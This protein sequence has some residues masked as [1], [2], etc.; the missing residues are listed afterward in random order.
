MTYQVTN[1]WSVPDGNFTKDADIWP[2]FSAKWTADQVSA[3][4][5]ISKLYVLDA[6]LSWDPVLKQ[7]T[8]QAEFAD[9]AAKNK[10]EEGWSNLFLAL[11]DGWTY[12]GATYSQQ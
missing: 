1:L 2:M 6:R 7:V 12:L 5:A 9:E 10:Q 11:P 3:V 4:D 8:I